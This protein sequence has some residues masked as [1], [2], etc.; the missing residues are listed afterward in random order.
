MN[1]AQALDERRQ[2][3]GVAYRKL[4]KRCS[5]AY[6]N[7]FRVL[8]E[9]ETAFSFDREKVMDEIEEALDEIERGKDPDL[10]PEERADRKAR[11]RTSGQP[12]GDL[13]GE[14]AA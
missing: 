10:F 9:Q 1:R 12:N 8:K 3:L 13:F 5:V 4:A 6:S 7:V 14:D 2:E 11:R